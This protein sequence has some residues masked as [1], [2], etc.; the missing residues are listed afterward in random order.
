M[1]LNTDIATLIQAK[2]ISVIYGSVEALHDVSIEFREGEIHAIIGE[3]GAGKSTLAKVLSGHQDFDSGTL[4]LFG[5]EYSSFRIPQAQQHGIQIVHQHNPFFEDMT[6]GDYFFLQ[7]DENVPFIFNRRRV[8]QE[9]SRYLGELGIHL[10]ADRPIKSLRLS[11]RVLIDVCKQLR[12]NPRLL[13]LDEALEKITTDHLGRIVSL[14]RE[15]RRQKT[16]TVIITHR[17][18]DVFEIADRISVL[19]EGRVIYTE[20]VGRVEKIHL[21]Q[22][23]YTNS[24]DNYTASPDFFRYVKYN[25][26]IL[27]NLPVNILVVDDNLSIR[28]VNKRIESF[29]GRRAAELLDAS[30]LDVFAGSPELVELIRSSIQQKRSQIFYRINVQ[31]NQRD[32]ICQAKTLP[33][34]DGQIC[35]GSII[36][37]DDITEQERLREQ[38]MLTE[39]ISSVGLLAEGVAHE[40]NNPLEIINYLVE[41]IGMNTRDTAITTAAK[42][43]REEVTIISQIIHN[44]ISFSGNPGTAVGEQIDVDYILRDLMR[45]LRL[46]AERREIELVYRCEEEVPTIAANK[47]EIRQVFLNV[48]KNS[49]EAMP[50]GGTLTI[51]VGADTEHAM[52]AVVFEDTGVG[53]PDGELNSVF[54]PFYSTKK[55]TAKN[56]GLGLSLSFSIIK[57]HGGTIEARRLDKGTQF[58]IKLPCE[59]CE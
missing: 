39:N 15:I 21:V 14:I 12:R 42:S 37:L 40:I 29:S 1:K 32:L 47:T 16:T 4:S 5:K 44:L 52:V 28:I 38:L 57:R 11:E 46:G 19:K 43:I 9:V 58:V 50:E 33:I 17:V 30:V 2:D 55:Q 26:A 24:N 53:I 23:A 34:V 49:L 18:D 51:S 13:I 7:P 10:D 54:L 59:T 36:L 35:I 41:E 31:I 6:V 22:M 25:E 45:L 20:D 8:A 27:Q 3:H 48:L 56:S